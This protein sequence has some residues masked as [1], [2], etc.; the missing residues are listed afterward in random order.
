M[1]FRYILWSICIFL[2]CLQFLIYLQYKTTGRKTEAC[3]CNVYVLQTRPLKSVLEKRLLWKRWENPRWNL[4]Q[5]LLY[6]VVKNVSPTLCQKGTI[7]ESQKKLYQLYLLRS[8]IKI[9]FWY[10]PNI[11]PKL[12][13]ISIFKSILDACK[14][15]NLHV[16][17][18]PKS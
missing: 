6:V 17:N 7:R 8:F 12:F 9:Y 14:R 15:C 13:R 10:F 5:R 16:N 2:A 3:L 18:W 1:R 11:F 4:R